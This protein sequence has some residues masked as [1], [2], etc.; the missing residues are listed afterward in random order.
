MEDLYKDVCDSTLCNYCHMIKIYKLL[1]YIVENKDK[2]LN[3]KGNF[4]IRNGRKSTIQSLIT[5]LYLYTYSFRPYDVK[6]R[7]R[8]KKCCDCLDRDDTSM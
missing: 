4:D 2:V 7:H 6:I 5:E 1:S 8:N 3:I